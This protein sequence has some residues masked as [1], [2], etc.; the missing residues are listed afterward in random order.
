MP[1][2]DYRLPRF[3][4]RSLTGL[5]LSMAL[6]PVTGSA[7]GAMCGKREMVIEQ[8]RTVHGEARISVGL[9]RNAQIMETYANAET[10]SWTI[11]V[12]TANGL[13]CLVAA[14]EAFQADLTNAAVNADD[15]A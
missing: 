10:G 13:A 4:T 11:I 8:L 6:L 14:G 12:T 1:C 5:A 15:P 3:F 7:Q 2:S 9:Q